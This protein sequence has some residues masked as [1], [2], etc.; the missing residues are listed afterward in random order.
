MTVS[1]GSVVVTMSNS[2]TALTC[3]MV[4]R[5]TGTCTRLR[6]GSEGGRG[7]S[8]VGGQPGKPKCAFESLLW[9]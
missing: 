2:S 7:S 1:L 8:R 5:W 4:W 3:F 6:S 9:Y